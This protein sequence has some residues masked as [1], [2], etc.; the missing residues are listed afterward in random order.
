V[1]DN[2]TKIISGLE[3]LNESW[4][5]SLRSEFSKLNSFHNGSAAI[6]RLFSECVELSKQL[7]SGSPLKI[8]LRAIDDN[9]IYSIN[10]EWETIEPYLQR[11]CF[12]HGH[13]LDYVFLIVI[14]RLAV[15]AYVDKRG[16]G[17]VAVEIIDRAIGF[18]H[19]LEILWS[20]WLLIVLDVEVSEDLAEKLVG[21]GSSYVN[22]M[23]MTAYCEEKIGIR[24]PIKFSKKLESGG[25]EWFESLVARSSG[26]TKAPFK[27]DFS[28]EFEHLSDRG[29]VLIDFDSHLDRVRREGVDAIS[30]S[31]YGYD[32]DDDDD[33]DDGDDGFGFFASDFDVIMPG[34]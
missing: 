17:E 32:S 4:A 27:G 15:Y 12:H 13:C 10:E 19:D 6:I 28:E 7:N 24:P 26:F 29:L 33:E 3:P 9:R 11:I 22:S 20:L 34:D 31:R 30:H 1:N 14:K 8:F 25:S 23:L 2:K 5:Q 21:Y 18:G 16:W